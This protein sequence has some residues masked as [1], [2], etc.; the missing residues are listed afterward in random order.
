MNNASTYTGL[1]SS[2]S[3]PLFLCSVSQERLLASNKQQAYI[4]H[5]CMPAEHP[6]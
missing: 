5:A 6:C 4:A 1:Y 2:F 3:T